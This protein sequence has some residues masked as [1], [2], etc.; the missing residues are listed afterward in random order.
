MSIDDFIIAVFCLVDDELNKMLKG[1]KLRSR[2][3]RPA[4]EDSEVLTMEIVGE[5]LQKDFTLKRYV[6]GIF[7]INMDDS[8]ESYWHTRY[9]LP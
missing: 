3:E 6:L 2:G 4:L 7:G 5:F 8:G 9:V 1:K